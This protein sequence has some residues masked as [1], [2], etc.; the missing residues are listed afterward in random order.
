MLFENWFVCFSGGEVWKVEA[1]L[2]S[3][4]GNGF[5]SETDLASNQSIVF[6]LD[7]FMFVCAN[8]SLYF[9]VGLFAS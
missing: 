1:G 8:K 9:V 2:C 7:P 6:S 5:V 4:E 3:V